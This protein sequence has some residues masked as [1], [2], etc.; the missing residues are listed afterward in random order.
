MEQGYLWFNRRYC[1][2]FSVL[3]VLAL[4]QPLWAW[5]RLHP[6]LQRQQQLESLARP[7]HLSL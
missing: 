1:C 5:V 2:L 4:V 6:V 7:F 3:S